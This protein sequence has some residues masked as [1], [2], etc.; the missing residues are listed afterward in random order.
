MALKIDD[1][2]NEVVDFDGINLRIVH[3]C[4]ENDIPYES[5]VPLDQFKDGTGSLDDV[6]L[7]KASMTKGAIG[8]HAESADSGRRGHGSGR[9][10]IRTS[11]LRMPQAAGG[12]CRQSSRR[13]AGQV[14]QIVIG[15]LPKGRSRRFLA[16]R[17]STCS[18]SICS[19]PAFS[20]DALIAQSSEHLWKARMKAV[21]VFCLIAASVSPDRVSLWKTHCCRLALWIRVLAA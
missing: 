13:H 10:W 21:H 16:S 6:K 12:S 4:L 2:K 17:A 20:V 8:V 11:V 3:Y 5:S 15:S 14:N 19:R 18:N 7:I 1:K 9:L